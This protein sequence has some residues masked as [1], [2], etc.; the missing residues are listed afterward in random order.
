[1]S[2]VNKN[3]LYGVAIA[4]VVGFSTVACMLKLAQRKNIKK[5]TEN[6]SETIEKGGL[7]DQM[8][9]ENDTQRENADM[10]SEGSQFGVQYYNEIAKEMANKR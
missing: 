5:L 10:V 4:T 6:F 1:M 9:E 8:S 2:K 7:P 3:F